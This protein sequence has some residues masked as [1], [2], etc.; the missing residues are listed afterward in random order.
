MPIE[1]TDHDMIVE[2]HTTLMGNNGQGGLC[3]QVELQ[4]KEAESQRKEID[5][6]K[7]RFWLLVGLLAGAGLLGGMGI[8]SL[9]GG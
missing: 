3:R 4:R 6:L 5:G 8:S 9:L 2:I 7:L 1:K